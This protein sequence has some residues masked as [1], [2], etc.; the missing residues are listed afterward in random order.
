[1]KVIATPSKRSEPL[2]NYDLLA[3]PYLQANW[4]RDAIVDL[5]P[6]C[7]KLTITAGPPLPEEQRLYE[8]QRDLVGTNRSRDGRKARERSG[9][10]RLQAKG[11][12]GTTE[13]RS[14][15]SV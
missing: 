5:D 15:L 2:T 9:I 3:G 8:E 6:S 1:M 4:L 14:M 12:F 10:F 7:V 13:V 11:D